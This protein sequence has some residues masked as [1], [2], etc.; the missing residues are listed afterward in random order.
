ME[1]IDEE[2]WDLVDLEDVS[3]S[4]KILN[5]T[6]CTEDANED[7]LQQPTSPEE[8]IVPDLLID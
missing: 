5:Q 2:A 7:D 8:P 4:E 3:E 6:T 1:P